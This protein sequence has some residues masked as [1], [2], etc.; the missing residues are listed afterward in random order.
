MLAVTFGLSAY[1]ALL[2]LIE[3]VL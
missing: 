1:V 2:R 3:A